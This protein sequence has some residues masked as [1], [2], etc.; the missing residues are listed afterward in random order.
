MVPRMG[1]W[2]HA[3]TNKV[4]TQTNKEDKTVNKF[5][6]RSGVIPNKLS[7]TLSL[8][9]SLSL[10]LARARAR[11]RSL[12]FYLSMKNFII[13]FVCKFW[14]FLPIFS[15]FKELKGGS[16]GGALV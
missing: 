5:A 3:A 14:E 9:L 7:L 6:N 10:S 1:Q 13:F 15:H 11:T 8:S 12:S 4:T 16:K 2:R